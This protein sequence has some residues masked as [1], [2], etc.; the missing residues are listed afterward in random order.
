MKLI[1]GI[2]GA[3]ERW[4]AKRLRSN[5]NHPVLPATHWCVHRVLENGDK[6]SYVMTN[7]P[8]TTQ[9]V[10]QSTNKS[11][12]F[13]LGT[14][15]KLRRSVFHLLNGSLAPLFVATNL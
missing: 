13:P 3:Y 15:G 5:R 12:Q 14:P 4:R 8:R 7:D 1:D 11:H 10:Q 9:R 2:L 6:I